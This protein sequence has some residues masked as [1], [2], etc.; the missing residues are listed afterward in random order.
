MPF[1]ELG[2]IRISSLFQSSQRSEAWAGVPKSVP[3]QDAR[4]G[5]G[6]EIRD[7]QGV[8]TGKKHAV[9]GF[10]RGKSASVDHWRRVRGRAGAANASHVGG[11][12]GGDRQ[13]GS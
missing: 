2:W 12:G 13:V 6:S 3:D 5:P 7:G 1:A 10:S 11:G 8:P 4:T 9:V